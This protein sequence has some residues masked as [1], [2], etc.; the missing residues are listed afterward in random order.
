MSIVPEV[1]WA[2]E[3]V[4]TDVENLSLTWVRMPK[5]PAQSETL[6]RPPVLDKLFLISVDTFL[7]RA[8]LCDVLLFLVQVH[9]ASRSVWSLKGANV[10]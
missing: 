5:L 1:G 10:S 8:S 2:S 3:L 6:S 9:A 7:F 4:W